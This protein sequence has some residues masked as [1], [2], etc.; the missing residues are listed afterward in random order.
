MVM[1]GPIAPFWMIWGPLPASRIEAALNQRLHIFTT[2]W[3][4]RMKRIVLATM[5]AT[6][7]LSLGIVHAQQA[8]TMPGMDHSTMKMEDGSK[9][10][11][12]SAFEAAMSV[13]MRNM[14]VPYTG[15]ADVDFIRGMIPHHQGAIDMAKVVLEHGKDPEVR[16]LAEA[17]IRAQEGEIAFMTDWLKKKGM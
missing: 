11:S 1:T 6:A 17:V 9:S 7:A 12:T 8:D 3:R 13:M 14:M 15:D 16:K 4:S 10:P 2:T 5:M